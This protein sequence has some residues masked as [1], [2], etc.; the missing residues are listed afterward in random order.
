[1]AMS[2]KIA[3][4]IAILFLCLMSSQAF[5]L[6]IKES[7]V[8]MG[9]GTGTLKDQGHY[10]PIPVIWH[11]GYDLKP[12]LQKINL[13]P[14]SIVELYLEPQINPVASPAAN[15]EFGC[16]LGFQIIFIP[17]AKISPYFSFGSGLIYIT[18]ST[19]EQS[20]KYNFQ[21]QVGGGIYYFMKENAA[22]NCGYRLRHISN[23]GLKHPN[24]GINTHMVELGYSVFF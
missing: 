17:S 22:L 21:D 24:S 8:L 14:E 1:M 6:P 20:T 3:K 23:A 16:G 15:V 18:Q 13:N 4:N 19:K 5:A 10:M 7:G 2:S 9:L 12:I 11:I